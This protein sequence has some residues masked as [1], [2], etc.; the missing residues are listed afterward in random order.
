MTNTF[1][2][3][4]NANPAYVDDLYQQYQTNPEALDHDWRRFFEGYEFSKLPSDHKVLDTL[5]ADNSVHAKEIAVAKLIHAYR[6]RGHLIAKTNPIRQRRLHKADLDLS[7]FGLSEDDLDTPFEAGADIGLP[8]APLRDIV[9]HLKQTY[10]ESI[11]VEFMYNPDPAL[12][13]WVYN[14]IDPI[15]NRPNYDADQKKKILSQ[16]AKAVAF[17]SFLHTKYVGQK[18]FSLEGAEAAIPGLDAAI[19]QAAAYGA[20]EIVVGMAHRG[21]LNVLSAIFGKKYKRI[22]R[23]FDGQ[24]IDPSM[25]GDGD[26]KYHLGYSTDRPTQAGHDV[27][28]SL[29]PNPSHLEAV[30]GV[31]Q[32]VVYAK[33]KNSEAVNG[34]ASYADV[35]PIL[36]HGDAALAG[37]GVNYEVTNMSKLNGY[38]NGG[39]VHVVINNQLGYTTSYLEGRSSMYCTDLAKVTGSPVFHVS[40]D[41]PIAVVHAMQM[42]VAIRYEFQMDVYVDILGYRRYGHNEGDEPRFTQ[43]VMYDI[44]KNHDNV[45]NL[46]ART[47]QAEGIVDAAYCE[48]L[49]TDMKTHLQSELDA[50]RAEDKPLSVDTF[51]GQWTQLR[52]PNTQDFDQS[53]KTAVSKKKLDT[54]MTALTR[55]EDNFPLFSKTK[56]ILDGRKKMYADGQVDWAVA[57][58]LAYGT[59]LADGHAVRLSGQDAQRG[60]FSHR[61]AVLKHETEEIPYIPLN[62]IHEKQAPFTVYNS[63]LSE[64]CVLGFELGCSWAQPNNLVIWE[65]QFGDFANGAQIVIDQFLSS[66]ASKWHRWSGLTL[67]LPHGYE[68]MGPEHS[69]ARLERF[70][71]LCG[72]NNM[73]VTNITTP[74]NIFHALRRQIENPFRIPLVVMSPKSL[75]RHPDVMSPVESLTKGGFQEVIDDAF[76]K[77]SAVKRVVLCSGKLYYDLNQYR[78]ANSINTVALVRLEQLYPLPETALRAIQQRYKSAKSYVWVQEEPEN[79]GAWWYLS[80]SM[81]TL[82]TGI[83]CVSRK[84]SASPAAGNAKTHAKEQ[85]SLIESAFKGV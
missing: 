17:E 54:V 13:Q 71:Q 78:A 59:L 23:E 31:V 7:Y 84:V 75:L 34:H 66:S 81:P 82:F 32:G 16:V 10:C 20:K 19:E 68:G 24:S 39:T 51:K 42:A 77:P 43:P 58:Q 5:G 85:D 25:G 27:H 21:R 48:Q 64:Y 18:R 36:I 9:A 46:F 6:S 44:I 29:I 80:Q 65:A 8:L 3:I 67:L 61:H 50:A 1:S 55:I 62:H 52:M 79:M 83:Q 76:V 47:L 30:N 26:V 11:G 14:R 60:T 72:E 45:Y 38:D 56:K 22:F 4:N 33:R 70:L 63:M 73:Y 2:Y 49:M 28:M 69:S 74:A 12:R 35:V 53:V 41:D 40:A 15:A 57:E 37:Q